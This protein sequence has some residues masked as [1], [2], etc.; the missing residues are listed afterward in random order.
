MPFAKKFRAMMDFPFPGDM[1]GDFTVESVDVHDEQDGGDGYVYGVRMV[2]RGP[3]GTQGVQRALRALFTQHPTTF[4]GYGNPYQ[5]WFRKPETESLGEQRYAVNVKG[6]GA[7]VY[8][9]PELRRFLQYLD[10]DNHLAVPCDTATQ[11][12][13]VEAYMERYRFAS[14]AEANRLGRHRSSPR[15]EDVGE[16]DAIEAGLR[17]RKARED[18]SRPVTRLFPMPPPARS[19]R[20]SFGRIDASEGQTHLQPAGPEELS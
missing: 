12:S 19:S 5:L 2:L 6:A 11:E 16:G 1:I 13:L 8:L 14:V 7:R 10:E 9:E 18:R 15:T 3:G 17:G 20:S 4:S